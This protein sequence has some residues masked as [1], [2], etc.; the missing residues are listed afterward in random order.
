M[1]NIGKLK[2]YADDTIIYKVILVNDSNQNNLLLDETELEELKNKGK[3]FALIIDLGDSH[4]VTMVIH[5][6]KGQFYGYYVDSLENIVPEII[7]NEW[8][9]IQNSQKIILVLTYTKIRL[10]KNSGFFAFQDAECIINNLIKKD[11]NINQKKIQY[12]MNQQDRNKL[13]KQLNELTIMEKK[14]RSCLIY[15]EKLLDTRFTYKNVNI[16]L[17]F[18]EA[19]SLVCLDNLT[20]EYKNKFKEEIIGHKNCQLVNKIRNIFLHRE[21]CSLIEER[22]L[23][24]EMKKIVNNFSDVIDFFTKLTTYVRIV[25]NKVVAMITKTNT[26]EVQDLNDLLQGI[27]VFGTKIEE[28]KKHTEISKLF[29]TLITQIGSKPNIEHG[30]KIMFNLTVNILPILLI[31]YP[32]KETNILSSKGLEKIRE[33]RNDFFH[34][35]YEFD[36]P[37][38]R[39]YMLKDIIRKDLLDNFFKYY[40]CQKVSKEFKMLKCNFSLTLQDTQKELIK[41]YNIENVELTKRD[42]NNNLNLLQLIS[43][44]LKIM[45]VIDNEYVL[46]EREMKFKAATLKV[47]DREIEAI[48]RKHIYLM[49]EDLKLKK[50]NED[51][52]ETELKSLVG[53]LKEIYGIWISKCYIKQMFKNYIMVDNPYTFIE[54]DNI[55]DIL[56]MNDYNLFIQDDSPYIFKRITQNICGLLTIRKLYNLSIQQVIKI[57][58]AYIHAKGDWSTLF[59]ELTMEKLSSIKI[60]LK[61]LGKDTF[62]NIP[63]EYYIQLS[64]LPNILTVNVAKTTLNFLKMLDVKIFPFLSITKEDIFSDHIFLNYLLKENIYIDQDKFKRLLE[65][66]YMTPYIIELIKA[67]DKLESKGRVKVNEFHKIISNVLS[68]KCGK[69]NITNLLTISNKNLLKI[70]QA[71]NKKLTKV[72]VADYV[73]KQIAQQINKNNFKYINCL[74]KHPTHVAGMLKAFQNKPTKKKIML[75][76]LKHTVYEMYDNKQYGEILEIKKVMEGCDWIGENSLDVANVQK[77]MADALIKIKINLNAKKTKKNRIEK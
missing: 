50:N 6:K 55:C 27:N 54:G 63:K 73:Y 77:T 51:L 14:I 5:Y 61:I 19:I 72:T 47:I 53:E 11:I 75:R 7:S 36:K 8:N 69:Y 16:F 40:F 44:Y 20:D 42:V 4:W 65:Y 58:D 25:E 38:V 26:D 28:N 62:I 9:Q 32:G 43:K 64:D 74:S 59:T 3:C 22:E 33:F 34:N 37:Q 24:N 70:F 71:K 60:K 52:N 15:L 66:E 23:E 21:Y 12:N 17:Y 35:F 31:M 56:T 18:L 46:K 45:I 39:N 48:D 29:G 10:P 1:E 68:G 41:N 49:F 13:I 57:Y 76:L 2:W 67:G 30:E